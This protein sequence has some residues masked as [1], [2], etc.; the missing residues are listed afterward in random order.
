MLDEVEV[1]EPLLGACLGGNAILLLL[2]MVSSGEI[3]SAIDSRSAAVRSV[4][5]VLP[6]INS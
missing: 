5:K 3:D 1:V 4:L 2:L 6:S